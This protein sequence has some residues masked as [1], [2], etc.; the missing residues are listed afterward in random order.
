MII[1]RS[2]SS[3]HRRTKHSLFLLLPLKSNRRPYYFSLHI[4]EAPLTVGSQGVEHIYL[5]Y[6]IQSIAVAPTN[7]RGPDR[8]AETEQRPLNIWISAAVCMQVWG[9]A[10]VLAQ[11]LFVQTYT[12]VWKTQ[13][14]Q[15]LLLIK[16]SPA[17][18]SS[19][20]H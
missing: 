4:T 16:S 1:S 9:S 3:S 5:K 13:T 11:L 19:S 15:L 20:P 18:K 8:A 17:L 10:L 14:V 12:N 6:L 2:I 7:L